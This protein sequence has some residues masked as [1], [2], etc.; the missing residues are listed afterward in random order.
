MVAANGWRRRME[1]VDKPRLNRETIDGSPAPFLLFTDVDV[2]LP[3]AIC[4][5]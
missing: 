4:L 3:H 5:S 1:G 2:F